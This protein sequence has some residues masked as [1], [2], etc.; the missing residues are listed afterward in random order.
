MSK[1]A[2]PN[3][4]VPQLWMPV[5]GRNYAAAHDRIKQAAAA[6]KTLSAQMREKP[7]EGEALACAEADD[8]SEQV[9]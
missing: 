9:T 8:S 5:A 6:G 4:A 1:L 2:G 3:A 7:A